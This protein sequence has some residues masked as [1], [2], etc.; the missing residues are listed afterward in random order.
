MFRYLCSIFFLIF[1]SSF[2]FAFSGK[3]DRIIDGDTIIISSTNESFTCR[4]YGIDAPE[5]K[6][7]FGKESTDFLKNLL[8]GKIVE[9]EIL[10]GDKYG[11]KICIIESEDKNINLEMLR[12]GFAWAYIKYLN[13]KYE[14]IFLNAELEA[15]S[16]KRG[17]W[18]K[19]NAIPPWVFR[20][21]K[22]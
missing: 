19:E 13:K 18:K 6:Q 22:R 9:Y 2:S 4:L 12:Q 17:L 7:T 1:L 8:I 11:R 21:N 3:I 10:D 14:K 15:K 16:F 5:K 20:R